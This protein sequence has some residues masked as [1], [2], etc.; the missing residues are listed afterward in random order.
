MSQVK[1]GGN[2][3]KYEIAFFKEAFAL[4]D[5]NK[6]GTIDEEELEQLASSLGE[7]W[8]TEEI[9]GLIE[10]FDPQQTDRIDFPNLLTQFQHGDDEDP[11]DFAQE[12]FNLINGGADI[13]ANAV[14][15]YL[16]KIGQT[17]IDEESTEIINLVGNGG[18]I[19]FEDFKTLWIK[20]E[21]DPAT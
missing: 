16:A 7:T 14:R 15:E 3:T 1:P 8:K 10:P 17:I 20:K 19:T 18:T 13:D 2:L 4:I 21:A 9:K 11:L 12:A 6:D 5:T